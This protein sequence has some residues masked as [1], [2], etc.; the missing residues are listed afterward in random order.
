MIILPHVEGEAIIDEVMNAGMG[1]LAHRTRVW[2]T[3]HKTGSN[4]LALHLAHFLVR[5]D[6]KTYREVADKKGVPCSR[7]K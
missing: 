4:T 6:P 1:R 7:P 5:T 2:F 3:S